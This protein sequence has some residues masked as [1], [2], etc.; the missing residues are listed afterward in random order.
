VPTIELATTIAAPVERVFDLSRS[1]DFHMASTS[2]TEERAIGG[3]TSGLLGLGDEVT[4]SARHL[5]VRQS[6]SVRITALDRPR[7]FTDVMLRGAFRSMTHDHLFERAEPGTVMTDQFTFEAPLG[8]LGWVAERAFL[9]A[10]MRRFLERRN[11]GLKAAAE[12]DGW[13]AYLSG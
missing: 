13:R 8:P 11:R 2:P 5:G 4:W 9:V 6:L 7:S 1:V 10:Y 12:G 3:V